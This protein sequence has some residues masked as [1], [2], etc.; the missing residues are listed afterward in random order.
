MVFGV[1][2]VIIHSHKPTGSRFKKY[3][4]LHWPTRKKIIKYNKL[5]TQ[6]K[7]LQSTCTTLSVM[8]HLY[9]RCRETKKFHDFAFQYSV[10]YPK[11]KFFIFPQP[12]YVLS[13]FLNLWHFSASCSYRK[14]SYKKSVKKS[15]P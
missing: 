14:G 13:M 8:L 1:H 10:H 12:P 3:T 11:S 4:L 2:I 6:N 9:E 15:G 5:K 7:V